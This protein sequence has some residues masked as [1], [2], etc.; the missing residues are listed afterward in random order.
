M[1]PHRPSAT[2][3]VGAYFRA[4]HHEHDNPKL[5][6]DPLAPKLFTPEERRFLGENLAKSTAIFDP[7]YEGPDA[8]A[9][10]MRVSPGNVTLSRSRFAE[11]R[12]AAATGVRQYVILGAGLDTYAYRHPGLPVFEL[13]HPATQADKRERLARLGPL[14][15]HLHLIPVDLGTTGLAEALAGTGYDPAL[16]TF[17]S[18]L[19][20]TYYLGSE[21]VFAT[22]Q[23][24][25]DVSPAGSHVVWDYLEPAAF[26][27]AASREIQLMHT[28]ARTMGEPMLTALDPGKLAADLQAVGLRLVEDL[29]TAELQ[30]S[31]F[32][33]R[34][35]GYRAFEH[36]HYAHA[37]TGYT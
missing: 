12:L 10:A 33:G 36:F 29:D 15:A 17:F 32:A 13:D 22:F 14:P 21:A 5:F 8:L 30:A 7:A 27:D 24:M 26:S 28:F 6:D 19:G 11:D 20:V 18:W 25:A 9:R 2:A 1:Q 16:P 35:D 37:V 23:A 3:M 4:Y 34:T 31:L